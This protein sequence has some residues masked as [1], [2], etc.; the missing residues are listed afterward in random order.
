MHTRIRMPVDAHGARLQKREATSR[1]GLTR[2]MPVTISK[3]S[4]SH[5]S[6]DRA[7]PPSPQR[8]PPRS[9]KASEDFLSFMLESFEDP[10]RLVRLQQTFKKA[11]TVDGRVFLRAWAARTEK[12]RALEDFNETLTMKRAKMVLSSWHRCARRSAIERID[13]EI[14]SL[15]LGRLDLN[16]SGS[17]MGGNGVPMSPQRQASTHELRMHAV[18]AALHRARAAEREASSRASEQEAA[19]GSLV[20]ELKREISELKMKVK[21]A[22][23]KLEFA[24]KEVAAQNDTIGS[25]CTMYLYKLEEMRRSTAVGQPDLTAEGVAE[26]PSLSG[27]D[28]HFLPLPEHDLQ[29]LL[30]GSA[31]G[32]RLAGVNT[33]SSSSLACRPAPSRR[34]SILEPSPGFGPHDHSAE[35]T[36]G[37]LPEKK[38]A[39]PFELE[40]GCQAEEWAAFSP[41]SPLFSPKTPRIG[42]AVPGRSPTKPDL[43]PSTPQLGQAVPGRSPMKATVRS[44]GAGAQ[45]GTNNTGHLQRSGSPLV[46]HCSPPPN[47]RQGIDAL[48][49]SFLRDSDKDLLGLGSADTQQVPENESSLSEPLSVSAIASDEDNQPLPSTRALPTKQIGRH[50]GRQ[51]KTSRLRAAKTAE[52]IESSTSK[53]DGRL[54]ALAQQIAKEFYAEK[55]AEKREKRPSFRSKTFK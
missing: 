22:E 28:R 54:L 24:S 12:V 30:A 40:A 48:T 41:S 14:D 18:V 49:L 44:G 11:G 51:T 36:G 16:G 39:S 26:G 45:L 34:I 21:H 35:G 23:D 52:R 38:A 33:E 2:V 13:L 20:L 31:G 53:H 47:D 43:V 50:L 4:S 17:I 32:K 10:H 55:R 15:D 19:H 7:D 46:M 42:A 5:L 1:E 6:A 3:D 25:L 37:E 27:T 9:A 8:P 29:A